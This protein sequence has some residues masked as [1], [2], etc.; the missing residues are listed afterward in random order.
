MAKSKMN[1]DTVSNIS[2]QFRQHAGLP[3]RK[4]DSPITNDGNSEL[5]IRTEPEGGYGGEGEEERD[6]GGSTA[7]NAVETA[8]ALRAGA[9]IPEEKKE[10]V[11]PDPEV[12]LEDEKPAKKT[13]AKKTAAKKG[14]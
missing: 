14:K 9:A 13:A 4:D 12:T 1:E 11:F 7:E 6:L 2:R 5:T 10:D 8:E 3:E